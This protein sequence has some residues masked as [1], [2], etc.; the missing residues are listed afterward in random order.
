MSKVPRQPLALDLPVRH[1]LVLS[2][3]GDAVVLEAIEKWSEIVVTMPR[4]VAVDLEQ[5]LHDAL[6]DFCNET[7]PES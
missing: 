6:C 2:V 7:E 5:Q 4:S 3:D 1:N